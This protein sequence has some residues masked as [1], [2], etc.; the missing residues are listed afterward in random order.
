MVRD[1]IVLDLGDVIIRG[2]KGIGVHLGDYSSYYKES[3]DELISF[4][5][6]LFIGKLTEEEFFDEIIHRY[7]LKIQKNELAKKFRD[8]FTPIEDMISL[9]LELS[10]RY[11]TIIFSDHCREW[12]EYIYNKYNLEKITKEKN[13]S[14]S[15]GTLKD[16]PSAYLNLIEQINISSLNNWWYIDDSS[17]NCKIAERYG[18]K[19]VQFTNQNHLFNHLKISKVI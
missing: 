4:L 2:T 15:R 7:N 14:F 9:S 6:D 3:S 8:Y 17:I 10:K 12:I 13:F 18:F 19:V 5:Q 1:G 11:R 16:N